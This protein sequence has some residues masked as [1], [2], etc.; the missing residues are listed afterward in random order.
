MTTGAGP[1]VW[2]ADSWNSGRS[3]ACDSSKWL[4]RKA[5]NPLLQLTAVTLPSV[6]SLF[7]P[8]KTGKA[9]FQCI[10]KPASGYSKQGN[11]M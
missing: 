5:E 8:I 4:C 10:P 9:K 7:F 3:K 1:P 2:T 11:N 6:P